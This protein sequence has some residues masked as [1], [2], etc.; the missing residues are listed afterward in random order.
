MLHISF[1]REVV[2]SSELNSPKTVVLYQGQHLSRDPRDHHFQVQRVSTLRWAENHVRPLGGR[3][4]NGLAYY[5]IDYH[6]CSLCY[7]S[8]HDHQNEHRRRNIF[9]WPFVS[10]NLCVWSVVE[11]YMQYNVSSCWVCTCLWTTDHEGLISLP[12]IIEVRKHSPTMLAITCLELKIHAY[13]IY[14]ISTD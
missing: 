13:L 14:K 6:Q 7:V 9:P 1:H 3:T 10:L 11:E 8:C 5:S 4:N 12:S 2:K